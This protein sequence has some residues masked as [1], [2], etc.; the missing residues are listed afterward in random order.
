MKTF[1]ITTFFMLA[2]F[3]AVFANNTADKTA[4]PD[5]ICAACNTPGGLAANNQTGTTALLSWGAVAGAVSYNVEV[6]NA[7]GNPNFFKVVTNVTTTS[8]TVIGLLPN[9]NYKFKV[10]ARCMGGSKSSWTEWK[11]FNSS[12][13]GGTGACSTP[14]GMATSGITANSATLSWNAVPGVSGYRVNIENGSGNPIPLNLTVN[15]P[16]TATTYT[17]TGLLPGRNYKWKVRSLCGTQTSAWSPKVNFTTAPNIG[18]GNGGSLNITTGGNSQAVLQAYPNPSD[19]LLTVSL[20]GDS[21]Q[22]EYRVVNLLGNT[23]LTTEAAANE[24]VQLDLSYLPKGIY[25]IAAQSGGVV[26]THKIMLD[27]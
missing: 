5:G 8:Y 27:K 19:G 14:G 22:V 12:V 4:R 15:L 23:V 2:G 18:T 17:V 16:A 9:L 1:L 13:G 20:S 7:S 26:R 25:L 10:R 24:Q 11:T 6:E 21:E 3:S